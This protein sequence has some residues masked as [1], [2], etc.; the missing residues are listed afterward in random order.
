[1][2]TY[3]MLEIKELTPIKDMAPLGPVVSLNA[4]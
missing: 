2:R 3:L 1:M 4:L